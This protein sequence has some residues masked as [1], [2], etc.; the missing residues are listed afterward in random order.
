[1]RNLRYLIIVVLTIV[2]VS[3]FGVKKA[4]ASTLLNA[5]ASASTSRPSPSAPLSSADP[6]T[7]GSS[8]VTVIDNLSTFLASDTAKFFKTGAY[9]ETISIATTSATRTT[10][11]FT[12]G[13]VNVQ[14]KTSVIAVP[15]TAVHTI[16]FTTQSA[17]PSG[18]KIVISYPN[19][20]T[21]TD[22]NAASPSAV[23]Y[24]FNNLS[25]G[26]IKTKVGVGAGAASISSRTP[27]QALTGNATSTI[28]CTTT[29]ATINTGVPIWIFIGC[30]AIDSVPSCSTP[31]PTL[32]NPTNATA[33]GAGNSYNV[34]L[35]TQDAS[36]VPLDT[37]TLKIN[38][39]E[40]VFVVAHV[41]PT[42]TFSID[43]VGSGTDMH[44]T[45]T[46]G[47][48]FANILTS[49]GGPRGAQP[50][51]VNMGTIQNGSD[52]YEAQKLTVTTNTNAGYTITATS[53]GNF[54]NPGTG[55]IIPN[56]QGTVTANNTPAPAAVNSSN[57]GFGIHPCDAQTYANTHVLTQWYSGGSKGNPLF[58][59][60]ART[61]YYTLANWTSSLGNENTITAGR[62]VIYSLY[63][64][65]PQPNTAPG[66]YWEILTYNAS[67][68]F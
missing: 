38:T 58:A 36:S 24:M 55:V 27:S 43:G 8:Q 18:G 60:P 33:R 22:A 35:Q 52:S 61:F 4:S 19:T 49:T 42:F 20:Q 11:N 44:T 67:A 68:T 56:T 65:A 59:N 66:D 31:V 3:G 12:A 57:G 14:N 21:G 30:S 28:T 64:A 46:C 13:T 23:T 39:I 16:A 34:T 9:S 5:S 40:S 1:M 62:D 17:I 53:S 51:E 32:I 26:N 29:G 7:A 54:M 6:L 50:T 10:L 2:L 47:T 41:D 63:W 15:I 45:A 25:S 48:T 37:S